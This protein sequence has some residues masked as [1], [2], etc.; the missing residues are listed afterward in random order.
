[1]VDDFT[2]LA[3]SY[4]LLIA[5]GIFARNSIIFWERRSGVRPLLPS[6]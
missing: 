2:S 1:L 3:N 5:K 4:N 6:P